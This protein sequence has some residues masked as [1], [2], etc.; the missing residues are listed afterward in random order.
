M[1]IEI[2][3]TCHV[4]QC[5]KWISEELGDWVGVGHHGLQRGW[6]TEARDWVGLCSVILDKIGPKLSPEHKS[7]LFL[8]HPV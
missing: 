4:C 5:N 3:L 1:L 8:G 6:K 2:V 7:P